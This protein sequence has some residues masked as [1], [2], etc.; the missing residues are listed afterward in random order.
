M[1]IDFKVD[2]SKDELFSK[3][4]NGFHLLDNYYLNPRTTSFPR[5]ARYI[6]KGIKFIPRFKK[7][8]IPL[9]QGSTWWALTSSSIEY[10]LGYLDTYPQYKESFR[11]AYCPDEFFFIL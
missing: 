11:Y 2:F 10:V 4:I 1:R 3:R 6:D 5:L 8:D 7:F 9:Y